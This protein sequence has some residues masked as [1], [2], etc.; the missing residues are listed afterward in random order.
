MV[1][2]KYLHFYLVDSADQLFSLIIARTMDIRLLAYLFFLICINA[3]ADWADFTAAYR[4]DK[5][6]SF[7]S[8]LPIVETSGDFNIPLVEGYH[9]LQQGINRTFKLQCSLKQHLITLEYS[10]LAPQATGM[11]RGIGFTEISGL[12][13]DGNQIIGREEINSGCFFENTL[14]S[15]K[16]NME[17]TQF[18]IERCTAK[19]WHGN[20][21]YKYYNCTKELNDLGN[22]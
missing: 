9:K 1:N 10:S 15:L 14:V 21:G 17:E 20:E 5:Q 6:A 22:R 8:L 13:I 3:K 19:G 2:K 12:K 11:C 16:L 7:F 18:T 4:C